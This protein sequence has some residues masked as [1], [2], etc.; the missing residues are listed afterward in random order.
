MKLIKLTDVE[1]SNRQRREFKENA[2]EVLS[3]SIRNK[4]LFHP[5]VLRND[6]K[7]LVAGERRL[8]AI[9]ALDE[10]GLSVTHDGDTLPQGTIPFITLGD[11]SGDALMEAELE[12]NILREDLTYLE[13]ATAIADLHLLRTGQSPGQTFRETAEELATGQSIPK[14]A[15]DV[16]DS[17]IIAEFKNDPILD[18]AKTQKEAIKIIKRKKEKELIAI[19]ASQFNIE[20]TPHTLTHGDFR[21]HSPD[22]QT[23]TIDVIITDPPYGIG[24]HNFG[25]MADATHEYEDSEEYLNQIFKDF[26]TQANR[27]TKPTAHMYIFC[28]IRMYPA[29]AGRVGDAGWDVWPVP[30]IW[31]KSNGMLPEPN[32]GP[33]RCYE[34]IIFANKGRKQVTAVY[35]DVISV[36]GLTRP[37]F[38]AQ[39]PAALYTEI[40]RRSVKPGDLIW[41]P[42][43][44]AGPVFIAA[45]N[46]SVR[47]IGTELIEEK[48]N[49]AKLKM[50]STSETETDVLEGF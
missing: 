16:R 50:A 30:L 21:T 42:F 25:D 17:L 38:G 24:A 14:V 26:L 9:S 29:L 47:A 18:K 31:S 10:L 34:T 36:P 3:T 44:G 27:V 15:T 2:I 7:T 11:L 22:I 39:K 45:N 49:Y 35:P 48:Y 12:E 40:L 1:I 46:L 4:G 13:R 43:V 20:K 6:S 37:K 5:I 23:G 28:D 33:R 19:L 41:D 8:R 32:F